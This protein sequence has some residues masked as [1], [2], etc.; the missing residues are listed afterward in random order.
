MGKEPD[1]LVVD[2]AGITRSMYSYLYGLRSS[3]WG[4]LKDN[5]PTNWLV[6]RTMLVPTQMG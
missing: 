5:D 1:R 3:R 2:Q 6:I 4:T